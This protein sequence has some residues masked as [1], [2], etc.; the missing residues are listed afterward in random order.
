MPSDPG[1]SHAFEE[2][3]GEARVRLHATSLAALFEEAA[4]ALAELTCSEGDAPPGPPLQV[5]VRA[6]DREALLAAWI[7]ELVFLSE[8]H[9]RVWTQA[10]VERLTDTELRAVVSGVEPTALL[11][12]V[13][14]ATLHDLR[15]W[16]K[17]GG[18]FEAT[19]VLDV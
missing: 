7:D 3:T 17:G 16:E 14:A 11:T 15:I 19:L 10:R 2:H 13:K 12:Q 18:G 1:A 9:K 4:R 5:A 6:H 8:T